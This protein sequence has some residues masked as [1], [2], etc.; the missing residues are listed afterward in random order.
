MALPNGLNSLA[1]FTL[2]A[3]D[4]SYF[5]DAKKTVSGTVL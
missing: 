4:A 3:S 2:L 1:K 5:T